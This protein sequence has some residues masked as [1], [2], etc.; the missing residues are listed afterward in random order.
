[1]KKRQVRML[2]TKPMA[3]FV[4]GRY[5]AVSLSCEPWAAETHVEVKRCA[6]KGWHA[7]VATADNKSNRNSKFCPAHSRR[8]A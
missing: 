3:S 8:P 5:Q 2:A 7:P 1:M 6:K 4:E